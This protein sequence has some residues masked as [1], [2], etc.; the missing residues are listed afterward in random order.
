VLEQSD[1]LRILARYLCRDRFEAEDLCQEVLMRAFRCR[2]QFEPGT[3]LKAWLGAI[4]RNAHALKG[5]RSRRQADYDPEV[6]EYVLA[7][8]TDPTIPMELDD[9]RR[10]IS[11]LPA[12]CREVLLLAAGGSSYDEMSF[13][14][15]CPIGTVKSRLSR[16]RDLLH[17]VLAEGDFRSLPY[18]RNPLGELESQFAALA[19]ADPIGSK[20]AS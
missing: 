18:S 7:T 2:H 17:A 13:A 15:R 14:L 3:N 10:A 11:L 1:S 8:T 4:M 20:S 6:A 16:A 19:P 5:R 9:V 12:R